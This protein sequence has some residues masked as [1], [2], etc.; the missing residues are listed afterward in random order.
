MFFESDTPHVLLSIMVGRA[1][2]LYQQWTKSN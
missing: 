1:Q 2:A